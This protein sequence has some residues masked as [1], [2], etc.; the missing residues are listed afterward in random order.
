MHVVLKSAIFKNHMHVSQSDGEAVPEPEQKE[1]TEKEP[2]EN[3]GV[4]RDYIINILRQ[5]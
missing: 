5:S 4:V 1:E 2:T 3:E